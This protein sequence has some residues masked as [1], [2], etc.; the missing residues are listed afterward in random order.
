MIAAKRLFV[1]NDP[2]YDKVILL[3]NGDGTSSLAKD[4]SKYNRTVTAIGGANITTSNQLFNSTSLNFGTAATAYY[5]IPSST[6]FNIGADDF[7]IEA[8]IYLTGYPT[9]NA[10]SYVTTIYARS[11]EAGGRGL[12]FQL[13]GTVSSYTTIQI[14]CW[15]GNSYPSQVKFAGATTSLTLNRWYHVAAVRKSGVGY[16]FLDGVLLQSADLN[17]TIQ[18][19]NTA[20]FIGTANFNATY[21][22]RF[23]GQIQGFRLTRGIGRYTT[24]FSPPI[25]TL[26]IM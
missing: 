21:L 5:S 18:T 15:S 12:E 13:V 9:S 22:Y 14:T 6:D 2:Y 26:Q 25:N 3:L 24:S 7:T 23:K 19:V 4:S 17:N 11:T 8:F 16:V 10:G 20:S 1:G